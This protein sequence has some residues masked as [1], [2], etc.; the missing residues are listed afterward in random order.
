[1]TLIPAYPQ[2]HHACLAWELL[3]DLGP[4]T[5]GAFLSAAQACSMAGRTSLEGQCRRCVMCKGMLTQGHDS[6]LG[7]LSVCVMGQ[8]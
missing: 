5:V 7:H 4:A 3:P 1:M 2:R 6:V 8:P